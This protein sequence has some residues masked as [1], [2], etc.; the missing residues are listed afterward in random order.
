MLLKFSVKILMANKLLMCNIL[1]LSYIS[2]IVL[3]NDLLIPKNLKSKHLRYGNHLQESDRRQHWS[4][5]G[6]PDPDVYIPVSLL[7]TPPTITPTRKPYGE[8]VNKDFFDKLN[9]ATTPSPESQYKSKNPRK[10]GPRDVVATLPHRGSGDQSLF[11]LGAPQ[12][13]VRR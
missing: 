10:V 9:Y 8:I 6:L 3:D 7:S 1:C 13:P 4:N 12:Q 5:A 11:P 2:S